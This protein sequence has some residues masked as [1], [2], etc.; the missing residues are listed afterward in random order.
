MELSK[1][2]T[3][4]DISNAGIEEPWR[5]VNTAASGGKTT[6]ADYTYKSP[7]KQS[8]KSWSTENNFE[9]LAA[10]SVS[11]ITKRTT[12]RSTMS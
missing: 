1:Y 9:Q 4:A 3:V 5:F 7:R 12:V 6:D 10:R 11:W 8:L 2:H